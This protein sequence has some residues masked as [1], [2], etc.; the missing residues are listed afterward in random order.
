M[1]IQT[2]IVRVSTELYNTA[3]WGNL[4][5]INVQSAN[6]L[7]YRG[8]SLSPVFALNDLPICMYYEL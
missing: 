4:I 3:N 7:V 8:K 5:L 6:L 1:H 2:C